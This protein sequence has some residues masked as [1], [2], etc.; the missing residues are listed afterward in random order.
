MGQLANTANKTSGGLAQVPG[1]LSRLNQVSA[2]QRSREKSGLSGGLI[3]RATRANRSA[4]K[5]T[6]LSEAV[7]VDSGRQRNKLGKS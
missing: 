7:G 2:A 5:K 4:K 6:V 3:A 1:L